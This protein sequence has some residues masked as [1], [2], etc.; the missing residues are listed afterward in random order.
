MIARIA[1]EPEPARIA[2]PTRQ[3]QEAAVSPTSNLI[4]AATAVALALAAHPAHAAPLPRAVADIIDAAA[5]DPDALSVVARAVK[6]ANPGAA[7]D[8]DA[9]VAALTARVAAEKA[10][11]VADL[12]LFEGWTGDIDLGGAI[13]TGNTDDRSLTAALVLD[14]ETPVW[15]QQVN[16][17][18]SFKS[19]DGDTTTDRYFLT[20]AIIRNLNARLYVGGMLWAE[21]DRLAG[22]NY[23]FSEG[24]G[25]GYRLV[26]TLGLKLSAEGGLAL[27][28]SEYLVRGHEATVAA[29][30]AGYLTWRIAPRLEFS[31]NLVTYLDTK[32][33]T[34]LARSA[35]T[36]R[37]QGNLSARASYEVRY[38]DN[39]PEGREL[40]DTTTRATLAFDF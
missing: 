24:L 33:S 8:V 3:T 10:R 30:L 39:P 21:R 29:R 23:R 26:Q 37:L 13:N 17:R 1:P 2:D 14:R 32:N 15:E 34:V 11:Q 36:T 18:V 22:H 9:H 35:L 20:Y 40:T 27:R 12:G 38:E 28:Q 16:L 31:Q 4:S 7:A 6:K 5:D 25:L 19:E